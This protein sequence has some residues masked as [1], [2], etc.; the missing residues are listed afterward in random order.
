[1]FILSTDTL[2]TT[3]PLISK[4]LLTWLTEAYVYH[5]LT[6]EEKASGILAKPRGIGY[7]IGLAFAMFAMQGAFSLL[8]IESIIV[9]DP[10]SGLELASLVTCS[11]YT[12]I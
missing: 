9:V 8:S 3:T 7:G 5:R 2:N 1:M 10:N 6:D 11:P 12:L 4:L